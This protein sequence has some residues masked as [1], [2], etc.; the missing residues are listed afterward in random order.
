MQTLP[1][2]TFNSQHLQTNT[3]GMHVTYTVEVHVKQSTKPF[4][5]TRH[6]AMGQG[7][8]SQGM[9]W[10][11]LPVCPASLVCLRYTMAIVINIDIFIFIF[12]RIRIAIAIIIAVIPFLV[13]CCLVQ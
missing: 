4:V 11:D 12:I 2:T 9:A 7:M 5:A 6:V 10:Y 1:L 13:A 3:M 8:E